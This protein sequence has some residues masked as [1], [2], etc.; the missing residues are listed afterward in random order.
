M[1]R[2]LTIAWSIVAAMAMLTACYK[3]DILPPDEDDAPEGYMTLTLPVS[4]S[5]ESAV[6]TR[7]G[8]VD[9]DG[10]DIHSISLFCFDKFGLYIT[11]ISEAETKFTGTNE[12]RILK[13]AVPENTRRIHFVA[14]QNL[15]TFNDAAHRGKH[16][17][18][19]MTELISSSGMMIYWARYK[20][21][22]AESATAF[23][24][25]L[26]AAHGA[27]NGEDAPTNPIKLLRNQA[28]V[29]V[30]VKA[31]Q[32]F[33]LEGFTVVNTRAFGT[34]APRHPELGFDFTF[35][36][37]N[38]SW[39][40]SDFVTLPPSEYMAKKTPPAD[41]DSAQETYVFETENTS[42]DPVSVIIK[43][44][45]KDGAPTR[46]YRAL[47]LQYDEPN[48][49][50]E[51]KML[52]RN[53]HYTFNIVGDLAYGVETFEEALSSAPTNNI[54]LS[55][56]DEV[57]EVRN[58]RYILGVEQTSVVVLAV[59]KDGNPA[60][61]YDY[62][63]NGHKLSIGQI[64]LNYTFSKANG[65]A[66]NSESEKPE[67][68]WLDDNQVAR[69]WLD[70]DFV[71]N[72]TKHQV[73]IQLNELDSG[74]AFVQD[75]QA[76][77][78]EGTI[79]IRKGLLQ[80]KIKI[81]VLKQQSFVPM[82]VTTQMYGGDTNSSA[83]GFQGANV[84]MLF[85]VPETTPDEL[86]PFE[87]YIS[88]DHLDLRP[89]A[90]DPLPVIRS[91]DPRYGSDVRKHPDADVGS[92]KAKE[93][94]G[95]KYVYTVTKKGDQ[96]VYFKNI[97]DQTNIE[98]TQHTHTEYITLESP[99]FATLRKPYVFS[100]DNHQRAITISNL[101]QYNAPGSGD[102]VYYLLVPPKKGAHATFDIRLM[103]GDKSTAGKYKGD[104]ADN[105]T[106]FDEF[107]LYSEY[108]HHEDHDHNSEDCY[109][110]F[111][112]PIAAG[113]YGTNTLTLGMHLTKKPKDVIVN[114]NK[115][116]NVYPVKMYTTRAKSAEVVRLASNQ[117]GSA[118]AFPGKGNGDIYNGDTYRSV[119]FELANFR[120]FRFMAS[121]ADEGLADGDANDG[122]D[123][124][125]HDS[126][127]T[128]KDSVTN[129]H[130][131]YQ[132]NQTIE[133]AF[134]ITDFIAQVR[135]N[136]DEEYQNYTVDPFGRAFKVFIDAPMLEIDET[137]ANALLSANVTMPD[138]SPSQK[139][140]KDSN[141]RF[142]YVVDGN[143]NDEATFWGN[144]EANKAK[145]TRAI[146]GEGE[147]ERKILP[148]KTNKIV[149]A[150]E[151]RIYA[152]EEEV[153]YDEK[154]FH[155]TN[156]PISDTITYGDD[157]ENQTPIPAGAFVSFALE[158][159]NSRIGSITVTSAGKYELRLRPEYKFNWSGESIIVAYR[160]NET[161]VY[162]NE[163]TVYSTKI[164]DLA[165][166]FSSPAI[167]LTIPAQAQ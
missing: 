92:D 38:T 64:D 55:I 32:P 94:I 69:D 110:H 115:Y 71:A 107:L 124:V 16:E 48:N 143:R 23:K 148:F 167:Q 129:V 105:T 2:F 83:D 10:L 21:D 19:V 161:T 36:G 95:Y 84:T 165:T 160:R 77:K 67:V 73:T 66:V 154:V 163:T 81:I 1:R 122:K 70:N 34:V 63:Y 153:I 128:E 91:D 76:Q 75:T 59:P 40:A 9:P 62:Y 117:V 141:G 47:V 52:R 8:S 126:P 162:S 90:G 93:V 156:T 159:D 139:F 37:G 151:I 114:G 7:G 68:M 17:E 82:W 125:D 44:K 27:T 142:V 99:Y 164:T 127:Q 87:V 39:T 152:D 98:Y 109:A 123:A 35:D 96:R 118:S 80:R 53:H 97:L 29:T 3:D 111:T 119:I 133:V 132:P 74:N 106:E 42:D 149:S 100:T 135:T 4:I 28:K 101:R 147:G 134:D 120:P 25:N 61:G 72:D 166:L 130:L 146:K 18:Q 85:T 41:V 136:P 131:T 108:L 89:E 49:I 79:L 33:K 145:S 144:G 88:V 22:K 15:G 102:P 60:N 103:D 30:E 86:L 112:E 150:G 137:N 58:D 158:S 20:D 113:T 54:W 31:G 24:N 78:L 121:V 11:Y 138:G 45:A 56:D 116:D 50:Y 26:V 57:N 104:P 65:T 43:G 51:Y 13:V 6:Q 14:N 140:Y 157:A 155:V 5:D 46:Y 12:G